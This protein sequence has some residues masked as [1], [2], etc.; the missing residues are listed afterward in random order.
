M[1]A[2]IHTQGHPE[3]VF[4]QSRVLREARQGQ[5]AT[6]AK[7]NLAD[8]RAL[9]ICGGSGFSAAWICNEHTPHDWLNLENMIRAA[10]LH[11]MDVIVRVCKGSYSDY[12]KPFECDAS[13]IMVPHVTTAAEAKKIVELCRFHPLGRRPLDGGNADG[14]FCQIPLV[15][16]IA[17]SNSERYLILQIESPEAVENVDAIAS[18]EGYDFLLFGPGDFSHLI[19][20]PGQIDLKEVRD[21]RTRVEEAARKHGKRC[22]A[23]GYSA[24]ESDMLARGYSI[25]CLG[26]DVVG[27]AEYFKN[28]LRKWHEQKPPAASRDKEQQVSLLRVNPYS[29]AAAE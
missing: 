25:A 20:K 12:I 9:E 22:F 1:P 26:S 21:A 5:V 18:V 23:V 7:L 27:L 29:S 10:K 16:Y 3:P 15:E 17:R 19:G 2:R 4:R 24:P 11:D 6:C 13:G 14:G 8:P 28:G